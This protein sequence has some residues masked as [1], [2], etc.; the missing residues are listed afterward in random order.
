M[1]N[2][3]LEYPNK[4]DATYLTN[5]GNTFTNKLEPLHLSWAALNKGSGKIISLEQASGENEGKN[6]ELGS[7]VA[8]PGMKSDND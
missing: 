1:H 6:L 3:L 4:N 8:Q 5:T 7:D 2:L